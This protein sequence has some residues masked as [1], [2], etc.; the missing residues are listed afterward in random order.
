MA[1]K[2]KASVLAE[3]VELPDDPIV[4]A[5][6]PEVF[7]GP[8]RPHKMVIGA[9]MELCLACGA[10]ANREVRAG[11]G[12]LRCQVRRAL[13]PFALQALAAGCFDVPI[14]G[15]GAQLSELAIAQGWEHPDRC[16]WPLEP[17]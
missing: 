3:R 17:D 6:A 8:Y 9:Q 15:G 12:S 16:R 11:P 10:L 1:V 7:L 4:E 5:P 14:L 13:P 2:F